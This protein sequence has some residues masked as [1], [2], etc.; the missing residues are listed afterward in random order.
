[1]SSTVPTSTRH[2]SDENSNEKSQP[3]QRRALLQAQSM[4]SS[5]LS[6]P[7]VSHTLL[8]P[9]LVLTA[10]RS[11][12]YELTTVLSDRQSIPPTQFAF[13]L[14]RSPPV[15]SQHSSSFRP[16][17][18]Y[19]QRAR[20]ATHSHLHAARTVAGFHSFIRQTLSAQQGT[21]KHRESRE[22]RHST[23]AAVSVKKRAWC[24]QLPLSPAILVTEWW[25]GLSALFLCV[26][27]YF[28]AY[29]SV[30]LSVFLSMFVLIYWF[31]AR[32]P[33]DGYFQCWRLSSPVP[34]GV[35]RDLL[36]LFTL[37]FT[38]VGAKHFRR[39]EYCS[40]RFHWYGSGS[41]DTS[42]PEQ[43]G[44]TFAS[45]K[46]C[47]PCRAVRWY[48]HVTSCICSNTTVYVGVTIFLCAVLSACWSALMLSRFLSAT[49]VG[50]FD[51]GR[52]RHVPPLRAA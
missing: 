24:A 18:T 36:D 29:F 17:S 43:H 3:A 45:A 2:S 1:M 33:L 22:S 27:F 31:V 16:C 52:E 10:H 38:T 12:V 25:L 20:A 42:P 49:G 50:I 5:S 15:T 44:G 19:T 32:G 47:T 39:T 35:Y 41:H 6:P 4:D 26:F 40:C 21:C 37:A 14:V 9:L 28:I 51:R 46:T 30:F 13:E 8:L 34:C 23:C 11:D 48:E 7:A